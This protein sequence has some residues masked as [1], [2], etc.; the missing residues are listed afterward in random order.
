M[1]LQIQ[2]FG[3]VKK[4]IIDLSKRVYVFVGY[5]N[6]GKTY[7]SQLMWSFFNRNTVRRLERKIQK[8]DWFPYHGIVEPDILNERLLKQF[9]NF[10]EKFI[11]QTIVPEVFNINKKHFSIDKLSI[12]L[13]REED[14]VSYP[15]G[16]GGQGFLF[17]LLSSHY[18][19][20]QTHPFFL[21]ANR[22]FIPAF[23]RYIY[24]IEKENKD[25]ANRYIHHPVKNREKIKNLLEMPYTNA[26]KQCID[27]IYDLSL[28]DNSPIKTYEDLY[29]QLSSILGGQISE[30]QKEG[31]GIKEFYLQLNG[32][33]ELPLYMSSS[34]VNQLSTLSL[35]FKYWVK[36]SNN[37]LIIDEPEE[38]LHPENQ[39]ALLDVLMR[40][41]N[42]QS[43]KIL[44]TTHSPFLVDAINNYVHL[45]LLKQNNID[46][47]SLIGKERLD[48]S[49]DAALNPEDIGVYFFDGSEIHEY[50]VKDKGIYFRDFH[51]AERTVEGIRDVLR[52]EIYNLLERHTN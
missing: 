44:L 20:P 27:A 3:P 25:E 36:D 19:G 40:F 52:S 47:E 1:K 11:S 16:T 6:S 34:A 33:K 18:F 32:E 21:P 43:N 12:K 23:Y 17:S 10:V 28:K 9:D 2:N 5:N 4:G 38:N 46:I 29:E 49:M 50:E 13:I 24:K 15:Y 31:L 42:R 26:V 14:E 51:R 45:G 41:V 7:L 39:L 30:K 8:E 37:F 48:I 35:Y 22:I